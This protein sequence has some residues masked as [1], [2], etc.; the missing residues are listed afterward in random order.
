MDRISDKPIEIKLEGTFTSAVVDKAGDKVA[1]EDI[2]N[3]KNQIENGPKKRRVTVD[4]S[5]RVVGEVLDIRLD[6]NDDG[7]LELNGTV[8]VYE[9]NE[10]VIERIEQGDLKAFSIEAHYFENTDPQELASA[11]STLKIA[12]DGKQRGEI[13]SGLSSAGLRFKTDLEKSATALAVFTV[14]VENIH[15]IALAIVILHKYF[16]ADGEDD[17][18]NRPEDVELPNGESVDITQ[19]IETVLRQVED[20]LDEE[21]DIDYES[22]SVEEIEQKLREL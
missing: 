5:G 10:E 4:H 14:I 11:D 1:E 6:R 21:L 15:Y 8:G 22:A 20:S 3:K 17:E 19:N 16:I 9:G 2:V 7:I 18:N 13:H 12:V